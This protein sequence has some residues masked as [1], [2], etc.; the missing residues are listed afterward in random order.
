[1]AL[2][3]DEAIGAGHGIAEAERSSDALTLAPAAP[4]RP[5]HAHWECVAGSAAVSTGLRQLGPAAP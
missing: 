1:M 3:K 4:S 2:R 5:D